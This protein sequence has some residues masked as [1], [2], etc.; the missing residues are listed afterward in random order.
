MA[1]RFKAEPTA[2]VQEEPLV[3][4]LIDLMRR[5]EFGT[6]LVHALRSTPEFSALFAEKLSHALR[7]PAV[8]DALAQVVVNAPSFLPSLAPGQ[9]LAPFGPLFK[10]DHS[11]MPPA[12]YSAMR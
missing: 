8:A 3:E 2:H 9:G 7:V 6:L 1:L 11:A 10:D 4:Q 5:P 12:T